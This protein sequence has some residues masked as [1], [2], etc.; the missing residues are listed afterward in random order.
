M[1]K[2]VS[3]VS[4]GGWADASGRQGGFGHSHCLGGV[5]CVCRVLAGGV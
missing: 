2:D 3:I 1:L 4:Q 5:A